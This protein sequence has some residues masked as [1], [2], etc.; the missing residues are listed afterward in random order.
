[1]DIT[2][3]QRSK[4]TLPLMGMV[5][6]AGGL[7]FLLAGCADAST[8]DPAATHPAT[9]SSASS[10]ASPTD[11]PVVNELETAEAISPGPMAEGTFLFTT[12]D[13]L[14]AAD[15]AELLPIPLGDTEEAAFHTAFALMNTSDDVYASSPDDAGDLSIFS[16]LSAPECGWCASV[17]DTAATAASSNLRVTGA[18]FT[19]VGERFD[20]GRIEDGSVVVN[21]PVEEAATQVWNPDGTL[22]TS[23]AGADKTL[24]VQLEWRS[25]MWKVTGVSSTPRGG[26]AGS[27]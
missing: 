12:Q 2:R 14:G 22:A 5:A 10:D 27:E 20:G 11:L 19:P 18:T 21:I 9:T 1:M 25:D 6:V 7:A 15:I 13:V 8:N 26:G 16:A 3:R 17:I 24:N 4:A 23:T